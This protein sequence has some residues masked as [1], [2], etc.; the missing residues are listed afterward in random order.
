MYHIYSFVRL[1]GT[2]LT[3]QV[4]YHFYIIGQNNKYFSTKSHKWFLFCLHEKKKVYYSVP[5]VCLLLLLPRLPGLDL[6]LGGGVGHVGRLGT[7][8]VGGVAHHPLVADLKGGG[9]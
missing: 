9:E 6:G 8:H 4:T 2:V 5:D 7:A 1:V 3:Q